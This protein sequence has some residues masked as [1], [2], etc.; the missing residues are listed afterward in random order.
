MSK[1]LPGAPLAVTS[2]DAFL[3]EVAESDVAGITSAQRDGRTALAG[4]VPGEL[5]MAA[6]FVEL[7]LTAASL[8]DD[9]EERRDARA[10]LQDHSAI[11]S[12]RICFEALAKAWLGAPVDYDSIRVA[13]MKKWHEHDNKETT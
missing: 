5:A 2:V 13:L 11:Y 9:C 7:A 10:W 6:D 8:P 4:M 1:N 3:R 12:A